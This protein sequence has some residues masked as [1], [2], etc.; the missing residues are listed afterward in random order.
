MKLGRVAHDWA[1]SPRQAADLQAQLSAR[2]LQTPPDREIRFIAGVDAA[3]PAVPAP[4]PP[5]GGSPRPGRPFCLAAAVLWDLRE[6]RTVEIRT[7]LREVLFPY[8]PGL[9]SFREA[10]AVLAALE[11]L[12]GRPDAILCDGQGRAHPRRFGLACHV[13]W[14]ADLP[15]VGCAKSRL[16]GRYRE[17]GPQPGSRSPL[18]D[19]GEVVG[20]VVRTREG[21]RPLFVSVGHRIDL[22]TAVR[23]VLAC[24]AGRRL[25]EPTR[26]AD[27]Q[28]AAA[29]REMERR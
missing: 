9:L 8:I 10:P 7:A 5:A 15:T 19:R 17:P 23:L 22:E 11:A 4:N 1:L 20:A 18:V 26:L 16:T 13:G 3:F 24:T 27:R 21:A 28:A 6:R 12:E 2:I 14:I 29:A 25:P